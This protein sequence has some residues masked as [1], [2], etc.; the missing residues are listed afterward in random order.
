MASQKQQPMVRLERDATATGSTQKATPHLLPCRV[1]HTGS[2]EPVQ[3]FWEPTQGED[4]TSTAYFRGRKL[5]GKK[6]VLPE[7]YRGLVAVARD[8]VQK[9]ATESDVDDMERDDGLTATPGK[10][11]T[12]SLLVQAE[13]D[14]MVVWSHEANVDGA[15]D[16]YVKG[17]EEWL[18]LVDQIHSFPALTSDK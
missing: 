8:G 5:V 12:S 11:K 16:P 2:V 6:V 9:E 3:S 1:H 7:G 17:V 4:G 14:D 10:T 18:T 13:F 15:A